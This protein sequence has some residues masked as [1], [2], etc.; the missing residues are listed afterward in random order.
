[1][2]A[3]RKAQAKVIYVDAKSGLVVLN[4][5]KKS[6]VDLKDS[7]G[8]VTKAPVVIPEGATMTVSTSLTDANPEYVCKVQVYNVEDARAFAN[9][10]GGA[11]MPKVGDVAFFSANDIESLP[12]PAAK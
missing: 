6:T 11:G 7:K 8:K 12:K 4:I 10:L 5:G 2:Q 3:L 1:M 9:V